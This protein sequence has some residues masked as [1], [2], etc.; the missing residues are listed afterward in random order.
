MQMIP[1]FDYMHCALK[2][3][4]DAFLFDEVPVGAVIVKNNQIITTVHNA[5]RNSCDPTAH[6]EIIAIRQACEKLGVQFLYDCDLYVTLEPCMMC[7]GAISHA[8][9]RT[10]YFGAYDIKGGGVCHGAR[11]FDHALWKPEIIGGIE[12]SAC[13][14]LLSR[15]FNDKRV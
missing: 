6:A 7:A 1:P 9:M 8:R 11:V 14:E 15:F 4:R 10:V 2:A 3:A 5:M 12:E 13:A